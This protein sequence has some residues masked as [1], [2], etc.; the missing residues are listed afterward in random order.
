M[1]LA[2]A[3]FTISLATTLAAQTGPRHPAGSPDQG[4]PTAPGAFAPYHVDAEHDLNRIFRAIYLVECVADEV[5]T[6]LPREHGE[7][8]AFYVAGWVHRKRDGTDADLRWFGGDGRQLPTEGFAAEAATE[9]RQR[10]DGLGA[11]H[12]RQLLDPPELAVLFQHDL[13]RLGQRL[14]DTDQN[15]ELLPA[16]LRAA[17]LVALDDTERARLRNPLAL[18]L[19]AGGLPER[20]ADAPWPTEFG[21]AKDSP[22]REVLRRSTKLFDA[23]RTLLWSRLFL[24]HPD[25]PAALQTL[26]PKAAVAG[27]K[28]INPSVPLGFRAV[29]IQGIVALGSDGQCH[30][31]P[32][33]VDVRTQRLTNRDPLAATNATFTHDGIDFGIWQL[34]RTA[35]RGG[36]LARTFRHV[37]P[38]D[39]DLFRDYGSLKHTTYRAQCTLCHRN[40]DTP[41]PELGGFPVLRPHVGATFAASGDERLRLAEQQA[42]KLVMQLT[43]TR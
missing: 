33:V 41:E 43:A 6:A 13:L 24:A 40:T 39:Q 35:L 9:L 30:A 5:G 10:L 31:T 7:P 29:L 16:L 11:E 20:G 1:F 34:E 27:T 38:D 36:D 23:E 19:P 22:Y 25:G 4:L 26:L 2:R 14:L 12:R 21:G 8:A 15:P 32:V 18:A 28:A 3:A 17:R 37:A 42:T